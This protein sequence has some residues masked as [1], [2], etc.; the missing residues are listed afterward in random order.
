MRFGDEDH[1]CAFSHMAF[2]CHLSLRLLPSLD[3]A[4]FKRSDCESASSQ[5]SSNAHL[6]YFL[7]DRNENS[8]FTARSAL[9]SAD[10]VYF[11]WA[12]VGE[13][14]SRP[15]LQF[16]AFRTYIRKYAILA[17]NFEQQQ[18]ERGKEEFTDNLGSEENS[19]VSVGKRSASGKA[20]IKVMGIGG[21]G[22]NAVNRMVN[23]KLSNVEF[24]A[25]N[26]DAQALSRAVAPNKLQIGRETTFGRGA[27]GSSELGQEAATE[28]LAELSIALE[29]ADLVFISAGMG[30]GT[31]SGAGP[32]VARLAKA[33]GALTI[34]FVTEPFAFEGMRRSRAA[35]EGVKA[36]KAATDTV[37]VVPN[38][39]LLETVGAN[40]S[41]VDAFCLADDVLRQGVQGIS[42]IIT[43]PGLVNVDFADVKA[44]MSNAGSAMLGIGVGHGKNRA[45][46]VAHSAIMSPLLYS[47]SKP[48]GVVY[49]VTGGAD[50]TLH[51][52]NIAAEIVCSMADPN[53][54]VI[55]G[56]VIDDSFH[57]T[58]RMT[59][60]ATGFQDPAAEST[61]R[62]GDDRCK[63]RTVEDNI[64]FWEQN[65][66]QRWLKVPPFLRKQSRKNRKGI[67]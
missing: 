40:T 27:G 42:D 17:S 53:A 67:I 2:A 64:S 47:V 4:A 45:E 24:W 39:R 66:H 12:G 15:R 60:I 52:V 58:I 35:K 3:I 7:K 1:P 10:E 57:G 41:I 54:N 31:G 62:K 22:C 65:R 32:V 14:R 43:I 25:V 63:G 20:V 28:S 49:N 55:F 8:I 5:P 36:M 38:E 26:T 33:M 18:Q 46:E 51:E 29:G 21:G 30:G 13:Q 50:L 34:G 23:A 48:M 59:V 6:N 44:I 16:P 9:T 61:N 56:A 19:R 37:V 11:F